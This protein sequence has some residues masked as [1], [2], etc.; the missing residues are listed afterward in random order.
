MRRV[1]NCRSGAGRQR[2][3]KKIRQLYRALC[4][5]AS[6]E[7][8]VELSLRRNFHDQRLC[9]FVT[10][11]QNGF[12]VGMIQELPRG[13]AY[14]SGSNLLI[15]TCRTTHRRVTNPAKNEPERVGRR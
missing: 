13:R 15:P 10:T 14:P 11:N 2:Q 4:P 5:E 6:G 7:G 3:R 1:V 8:F 9:R 12:F